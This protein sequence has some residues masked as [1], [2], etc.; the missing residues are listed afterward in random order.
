MQLERDYQNDLD[1]DR[2]AELKMNLREKGS[3]GIHYIY[4]AQD[5]DQLMALVNT[6]MNLSVL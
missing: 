3:G 4:L 6:I 1:T 2:M 5:S